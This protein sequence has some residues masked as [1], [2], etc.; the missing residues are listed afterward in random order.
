MKDV[1]GKVLDAL[2]QIPSIIDGAQRVLRIYND[3]ER[4][5]SLSKAFYT[6]ILAALGQ[7]MYYLRKKASAKITR[8]F[9][10][11]FGFEDKLVHKIGDITT[12]KEAFNDEAD[13]CQK[14]ML[15]RMNAAIENRSEETAGEIRKMQ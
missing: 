3:S 9:I 2:Q 12:A 5:E 4:L 11:P 7:V 10:T 13:I 1:H 15:D 6:S 14:E 8:A